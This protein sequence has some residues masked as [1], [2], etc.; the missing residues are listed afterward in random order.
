MFVIAVDSRA[1]G[2]PPIVLATKFWTH[3]W[4]DFFGFVAE[5][6]AVCLRFIPENCFDTYYSVDFQNGKFEFRQW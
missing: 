6:R 4:G 5:G 2:H 3:A 1:V